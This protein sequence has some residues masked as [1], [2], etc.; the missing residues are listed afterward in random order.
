M[1]NQAKC[2]NLAQ[3]QMQEFGLKTKMQE[4]GLKT[5]VRSKTGSKG[6]LEYLRTQQLSGKAVAKVIHAFGRASVYQSRAFIIDPFLGAGGS[7]VAAHLCGC[8]LG[9][10]MYNKIKTDS[11]GTGLPT[12]GML[13]T[14]EDVDNKE[15]A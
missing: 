5:R 11:L 14:D 15:R 4:F 10:E 8:W 13:T 12:L 6:T 7:M 9:K 3:D 1:V 2:K